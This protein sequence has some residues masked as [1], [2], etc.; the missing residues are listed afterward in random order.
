MKIS[1]VF[2]NAAQSLSG[3]SKAFWY[4]C[5]AIVNT[6]SDVKTQGQALEF[7]TH[8]FKPKDA[9][10]YEPWWSNSYDNKNQE[11]RRLALLFAHEIALDEEGKT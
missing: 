3:G 1:D 2:W 4:C 9:H 11:A 8:L 7:F 6:D 10:A 5:D